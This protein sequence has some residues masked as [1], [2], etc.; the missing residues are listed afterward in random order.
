MKTEKIEFTDIIK[1]E[2]VR[3]EDSINL[4]KE[5]QLSSG[6]LVLLVEDEPALLLLG[7][8]MLEK[9]GYKVLPAG[10]PGAAIQI[11]KDFE[12]EIDL[13]LTDLVMPEMN[14]RD[15]VAMLRSLYP[16]LKFL[17]MSGY[18]ADVVG[19]L[20]ELGELGGEDHFIQ[21]PFAKKEIALK[22]R[23]ILDQS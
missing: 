9:L 4:H 12:G 13:L 11:A 5:A 14:G 2:C 18:T 22:I 8:M 19:N 16:E 15:L 20:G 10:T 3:L 7:K 21:K 23:K 6:E 1:T 17:F